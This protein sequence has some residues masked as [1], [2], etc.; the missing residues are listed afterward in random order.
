MDNSWLVKLPDGKFKLEYLY[1]NVAYCSVITKL[2]SNGYV[3]LDAE[4]DYVEFEWICE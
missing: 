3:I 1:H 4:I 2:F